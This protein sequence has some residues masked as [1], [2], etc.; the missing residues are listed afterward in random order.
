MLFILAVIFLIINLM[1][2]YTTKAIL[3]S[4]YEIFVNSM[5]YFLYKKSG[6]EYMD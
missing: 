1:A 4:L 2:I 3:K 6:L 5:Q